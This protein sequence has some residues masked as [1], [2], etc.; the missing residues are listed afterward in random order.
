[1][2]KEH[3]PTLYCDACGMENPPTYKDTRCTTCCA[4][5]KGLYDVGLDKLRGVGKTTSFR[6]LTR[7]MQ[8]KTAVEF[9]KDST[10]ALDLLEQKSPSLRLKRKVEEACHSH[11]GEAD[12]EVTVT[13]TATEL[14]AVLRE[15][16]VL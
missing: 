8:V 5:P 16:N 7:Y 3:Q 6:S 15:H 13:L 1:M 14:K 2:G 4:T 11:T 10:H 12:E 9:F